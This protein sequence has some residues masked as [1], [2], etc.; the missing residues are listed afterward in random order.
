MIKKEPRFVLREHEMSDPFKI[1]MRDALNNKD[2]KLAKYLMQLA[3]EKN[4]A[5][6]ANQL[7]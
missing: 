3:E 1:Q 5:E 4:Q 7:H 2:V 6:K